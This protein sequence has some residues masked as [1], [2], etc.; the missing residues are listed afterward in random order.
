MTG[1][2]RN[3]KYWFF[4]IGKTMGLTYL[5]IIGICAFMSFFDGGNFMEVFSKNIV[6]Y[7]IMASGMSIMAFGFM[8]ITTIFPITV[9]FSSRRSSSLIGM[10]VAQHVFCLLSFALAFACYL[11]ISPDVRPYAG[12]ASPLVVGIVC[13]LFFMGN[14]VAYLSDRFGRTLGMI[15]YMVFVLAVCIGGIIVGV[16]VVRKGSSLI[17]ALLTSIGALSVIICAAGIILD[18]IG[19]WLLA[20]GIKNKDIKF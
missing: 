15:L 14:I 7:L 19:I 1:L 6:T 5:M 8:N 4:Y 11:Y 20:A 17:P 3:I 13:I 16:A 2:E 12:A 18:A 10:N 9:S